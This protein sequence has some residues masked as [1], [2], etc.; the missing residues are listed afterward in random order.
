MINGWMF[1]GDPSEQP[2]AQVNIYL[3]LFV[4]LFIYLYLSDVSHVKI[5]A[6]YL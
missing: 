5:S 6:V 1:E 3:Y 4:F 2:Y